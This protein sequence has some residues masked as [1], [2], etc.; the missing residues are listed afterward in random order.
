MKAGLEEMDLRAR[1]IEYRVDWML[2]Y[3]LDENERFGIL[4]AILVGLLRKDDPPCDPQAFWSGD[5]VENRIT[6]NESDWEND[7]K[8]W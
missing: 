2:D 1:S 4:K 3:H 8:P 6:V 5:S 7:K